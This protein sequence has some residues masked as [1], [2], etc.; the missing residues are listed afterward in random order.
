MKTVKPKQIQL[1]LHRNVSLMTTKQKHEGELDGNFVDP[2]FKGGSEHLEGRRQ[3]MRSEAQFP[4]CLC[5]SHYVR[6]TGMWATILQ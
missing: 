4:D 3:P 1:D 6:R 2:Y 5:H